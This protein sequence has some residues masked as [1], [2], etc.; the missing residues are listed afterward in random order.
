MLRNGAD[1]S[2]W[3]IGQNGHLYRW[4]DPGWQEFVCDA[5]SFAVDAKGIPWHIGVDQC[6][7]RW[8]G[9]GWKLIP[10]TIA[11]D[12]AAGGDGSIWH[13]GQQGTAIYKWNGAG[14]DEPIR[15]V[16]EATAGER[17]FLVADRRGA[18]VHIGRGGQIY[19]LEPKGWMPVGSTFAKNIC[20]DSKGR[21]WHIG[22]YPRESSDINY[23]GIYLWNPKSKA[24]D[25]F[26]AGGF[27]DEV[28][29]DNRGFAWIHEYVPY[30]N[31]YT[32]DTPLP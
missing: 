21:L 3:H 9:T 12:V 1:G 8:N 17:K 2:I 7:Y 31:V 29:V 28:A 4:N 22:M 16:V 24:W 13:L 6:L 20:A 11:E 25:H 27:A 5:V 15:V 32:T 18:P 10:D 19:I 14:W 23:S 26:D 30:L